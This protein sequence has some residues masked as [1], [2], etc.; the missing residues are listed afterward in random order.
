MLPLG[1]PAPHLATPPA[2]LGQRF[3]ARPVLTPAG[4][5]SAPQLTPAS[6]AQPRIPGPSGEPAA[7]VKTSP[8]G[9]CDSEPRTVGL[10]LSR[11]AELAVLAGPVAPAERELSLV[12]SRAASRALR[13]LTAG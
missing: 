10:D 11:P 4:T 12:T 13:P 1:R 2:T 3:V 9:P 8:S 7:A 6:G 5:L